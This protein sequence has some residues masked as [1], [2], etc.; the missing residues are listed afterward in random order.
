MKKVKVLICEGYAYAESI[1]SQYIIVENSNYSTN[2][3]Y[4]M[5][6]VYQQF[7]CTKATFKLK[8]FQENAKY[9]KSL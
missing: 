7:V 6:K 5:T 3:K 4:V 1:F 2:S 8:Q 9:L